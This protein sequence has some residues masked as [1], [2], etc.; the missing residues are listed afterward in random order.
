MA[1]RNFLLTIYKSRHKFQFSKQGNFEITLH[2]SRA[3]NCSCLCSS[4]IL[5]I[6]VRLAVSMHAVWS[7]WRCC[8]PSDGGLPSKMRPRTPVWGQPSSWYLLRAVLAD[9]QLLFGASGIPGDWCLGWVSPSDVTLS[10]PCSCSHFQQA[11]AYL[12][13]ASGGAGSH[14]LMREEDTHM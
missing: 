12:L 10:S 6:N 7:A 1:L 13:W 2:V 8:V 9:E 14:S 4:P 11:D 5:V 3:D